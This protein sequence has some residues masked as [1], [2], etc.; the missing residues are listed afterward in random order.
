M[1]DEI[2]AWK[3][4]LTPWE[5]NIITT[6]FENC[7]W[8][9]TG[10]SQNRPDTRMFWFKDMFECGATKNL[11]KEKV[12]LHLGRLIEPTRLYA[13]GQAH[14]QCGQFHTDVPPEQPG[15]FGSLVYYY[16]DEW[17]PEYGGHIMI[18]EGE[19]VHS[20]WPE[21]NSAILFNSQWWHCP[22]EPTTFCRTQRV[23][24][25]FKFRVL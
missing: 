8:E 10:L 5:K 15:T 23:S 17:L 16:N 6:D 7:K 18:K 3:N 2:I 14:S 24:I 25:A 21:A 13:N 9:L 11:L 20:Y 19:K 12:E 4:F 22:L 1:F